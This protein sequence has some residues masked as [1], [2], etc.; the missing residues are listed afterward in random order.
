M[1]ERAGQ[2]QSA[3]ADLG[4][5]KAGQTAVADFA[6]EDGALVIATDRQGDGGERVGVLDEADAG[7]TADG[8][9]E[10]VE[11]EHT[12]G[13][14]LGREDVGGIQAERIVRAR[15]EDHPREAGRTPIGVDSREG[16]AV[17]GEAGDQQIVAGGAGHGP[18][19]REGGDVR[20]GAGDAPSLVGA[21]DD[22]RADEDGTR[23]V[24][25]GDAV[26][27][28]SRSHREGVGRVRT[29][30][31]DGHARDAGRGRSE[32]QV[33]DG[34]TAV[35]RRDIGAGGRAGRGAEDELIGDARET[36]GV[37]EP[38]G[39]GAEV[40]VVVG[41]VERRPAHIGADAPVEVGRQGRGGE[42]DGVVGAGQGEG[43]SAEAAQVAE[44]EI[45][46]VQAARGS[47]DQFVGA[48]GETRQA[49]QVDDDAIGGEGRGRSGDP[50]VGGER[51]DVEPERGGAAGTGAEV[52]DARAEGELLADGVVEVEDRAGV[53][54]DRRGARG[55]GATAREIEATT[56]DGG[57]TEIR[58]RLAGQR[59]RADPRLDDADVVLVEPGAADGAV[60]E[61][62]DILVDGQVRDRR[63]AADDGVAGHLS[64][65]ADDDGSGVAADAARDVKISAVGDG[66][67]LT[68]GELR[69]ADDRYDSR[70]GG[71]AR[72][73]DR[74]AH[75]DAARAGDV[76]RDRGGRGGG[77]VSYG[78]YGGDG[79]EAGTVETRVG[80]GDAGD[81]AVLDG[82]HGLRALGAH[83][84]ADRVEGDDRGGSEALTGI[85]EREVRD[86]DAGHAGKGGNGLMAGTVGVAELQHPGGGAGPGTD[87]Q[88]RGGRQ[89]VV[90][91]AAEDQAAVVHPRGAGERARRG[92][93][94]GTDAGLGET[95][96]AGSADRVGEDELVRSDVQRAAGRKESDGALRDVVRETRREA[97]G[98]AGQ[99]EAAEGAADVVEVRDLQDAFVDGGA[100]IGGRGSE[101]ADAA[102]GGVRAGEHEGA[103]A[104]LGDM[105]GGS[106]RGRD[107]GRQAR[108]DSGRAGV[109][110][111]EEVFVRYGGQTHAAV[112]TGEGD[113][114]VAPEGRRAVQGEEESA[115]GVR[116]ARAG[117]P[118][119]DEG[120]R[121]SVGGAVMQDEG[122]DRSVGAERE[123][124]GQGFADVLR[125]LEDAREGGVVVGE[126]QG[127][128]AQSGDVGRERVA[129]VRLGDRAD[130][131]DEA[132]RDQPRGDALVEGV[133][134]QTQP[135]VRLGRAHAELEGGTVGDAG[136]VGPGRDAGAGD[137]HVRLKTRRGGD[138]DGG[139][140]QGRDARG[141]RDVRA[142]AADHRVD[143]IILGAGVTDEPVGGIDVAAGDVA[144]VA[145]PDV[146]GGEIAT[147]EPGG[148]E[149]L[150][151]VA[152]HEHRQVTGA[153]VEVEV[154]DVLR[155]GGVGRGVPDEEAQRQRVSE[156][157]TDDQVGARPGGGI[158]KQVGGV[159]DAVGIRV[160]GA[161]QEEPAVAVDRD[162]REIAPGRGVEDTTAGLVVRG[163][164]LERAGIDDE[165]A[166]VTVEAVEVQRRVA[167]EADHSQAHELTGEGAVLGLVDRE[168]RPESEVDEIVIAERLAIAA[169]DRA[170]GLAVSRGGLD[171][172]GAHRRGVGGVAHHEALA[173]VDDE[174]LRGRDRLVG[175]AGQDETI[176]DEGID[177]H[178]EHAIE[179]RA[180]LADGEVL[181]VDDTV[182]PVGRDLRD[183]GGHER[184]RT[185][186]RRGRHAEGD[187]E[188]VDDG[189]DVSAGR[190]ARAGDRLA[191]HEAGGVRERHG[192]AGVG[193]RGAGDGDG[194][195]GD[196]AGRIAEAGDG[197]TGI[198]AVARQDLAH[199]QAQDVVDLDV[200]RTQRGGARDAQGGVEADARKADAVGQHPQIGRVLIGEG[201]RG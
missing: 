146:T 94:E 168:R 126:V 143:E 139:A 141:Q 185:R 162:G 110:D 88:F 100:P 6:R 74:G 85:Q 184:D 182:Q 155:T 18:G 144:Q 192:G 17:A 70:T 119:D 39:I 92:Q 153:R 175:R 133:G 51:A 52:E 61:R 79:S 118:G 174:G 30:L 111:M 125:G 130:G 98:A 183:R 13:R 108:R 19:D 160:Q 1:G 66:G 127:A 129:H 46:R 117:R 12:R 167:D 142:G 36:L 150:A 75:A 132:L 109:D 57:L 49:R 177:D 71:D 28:I 55:R 26:G 190:D 197:G 101:R 96:D 114:V 90:G 113:R 135:G 41:V 47:G 20:A 24:F 7:K 191:H 200:R 76:E 188:V 158:K 78:C 14:A 136:H 148:A 50:V 171:H 194:P 128:Q 34:E 23:V 95:T 89:A 21:E 116:E 54:L 152:R 43:V 151:R 99:R 134:V 161:R 199:A 80:E 124:A 181:V 81:D 105:S 103:P 22:G 107:E 60:E 179:A 147:D 176:A 149:D 165:V 122:V 93:G 169:R 69:V 123:I 166:V 16:E 163:R 198:D 186:G 106:Q 67:V 65:R 48:G 38:E 11:A 172:G 178:L 154:I 40:S 29:A 5:R 27:G 193:G 59:E 32:T 15:A 2:G 56:Q 156:V 58:K 131:V 195:E 170:D 104:G 82:G 145:S 121:C 86:L 120:A 8:V 140:A 9:I 189:G 77:G 115:A 164:D 91:A 35:E 84:A 173:G 33:A 68:E 102:A 137:A 73:D 44:G 97:Q 201:D 53:D 45:R 37:D 112:E 4:E 157:R 10:T 42:R 25:D 63:C 159:A 180:G 72:A 87:E 64:E 138:R 83:Q 31:G 62:A 187:A 3:V 196:V